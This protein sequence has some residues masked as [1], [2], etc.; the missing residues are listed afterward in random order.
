MFRKQRRKSN[1]I[2]PH[3]NSPQGREGEAIMTKWNFKID[4]EPQGSS[5]GFWYDIADGG[6]IDIDAVL[7]D[8]AQRDYLRKIIAEVRSFESA[9]ENAGLLNE[10]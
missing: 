7:T 9:L 5:A 2:A 4:A 1:Q 8:K 10:F 6:Y 3:G